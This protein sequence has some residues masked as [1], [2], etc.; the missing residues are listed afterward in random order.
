MFA[1]TSTLPENRAHASPV[2]GRRA[3]QIAAILLLLLGAESWLVLGGGDYGHRHEFTWLM[4]AVIAGLIPPLR[5]GINA[6]WELV[7][8]ASPRNQHLIAGLIAIAS[9]LFI[10][11]SERHQG[12]AI[13]PYFHDEFSYLL[14]M[15]MLAHGRLWMPAHPMAEFF[16][17]FYVINNPIY[18]SMYFPGTAILFAPTIWL[19]LPYY[20]GTLTAAGLCAGLLYLIVAEILDGAMALLAVAFM[21]SEGIFRLDAIMLL[22]QIPLL[23]LGLTMTFAWLRWRKLHA[24]RSRGTR[25]LILL[26]AASGWA[27]ITRPLD[28]LCF[29]VVIGLGM[30]MDLRRE[31][32]RL[33][34]RIAGTIFLACLPFLMLQLV[35]NRAVTGRFFQSPFEY[36]TD[37]NY[38]GGRYGF[39]EL[40]GD[41]APLSRLP[42]KQIYY[43]NRI[44]PD[45]KKHRWEKAG[46]LFAERLEFA[47]FRLVTDPVLWLFFPLAV[48]GLWDRRRWAVWG[49]FPV[50]LIAYTGYAFFPPPTYL[51]VLV[52]A[53][54]L[55]A[56]LP[57]QFLCE[58]FPGHQPLIR[59]MMGLAILS[60]T[61]ASMPWFDRLVHDQYFDMHENETID[62]ALRENV[63]PPAV[64]L[65]HFNR[66]ALID[67][68]RVTNNPDEEPVYNFDAID[69][70][71]SPII[72]AHD[73]NTNVDSIGMPGDAN[74]RLYAYF[75]RTSPQR[76]FY[77]YNRG[78]GSGKLIRLG[79]AR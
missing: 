30:V 6:L 59:T 55:L 56:V 49:V 62:R 47:E 75:S 45:L 52:P 35:F 10:Y 5:R 19:G 28:A 18:A 77:L 40:P 23:L 38:P 43:Q 64:V 60:L 24:E 34:L 13:H 12:V 79:A 21:L 39:R 66:D 42:Q 31:A 8:S 26:G 25:W 50:F 3:L 63:S 48:A 65:F 20:V 17:T 7:R 57:I 61:A 15:R 16:D 70:D 14:Q 22:S 51:A 36:Y 53:V 67:G 32:P 9:A 69:P 74:L 41:A 54:A 58:A 68:R 44:L 2:L 33:W 37:Q 71:Q 1:L 29:A 76:I 78:D 4:V 72:R 46:A 73:L 27:A 11:F